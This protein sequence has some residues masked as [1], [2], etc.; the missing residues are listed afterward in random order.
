VRTSAD[1]DRDGKVTWEELTAQRQVKAGLLG[2][3][4]LNDERA[5]LEFIRQYDSNGNQVVDEQEWALVFRQQS[6]RGRFFSTDNRDDHRDWNRSH[7]AV[8][9]VLDADGDRVLSREEC[10]A[11]PAR[12]IKLDADDDERIQTY[13]VSSSQVEIP[14]MPARSQRRSSGPAL[15]W[16][17]GT[18]TDWNQFIRACQNV[19]SSGGPLATG[20]F[21]A[22]PTLFAA[23]DGDANGRLSLKE[24][25]QLAEVKPHVRLRVTWGAATTN[26]NGAACEILEWSE[27]LG[28]RKE[29][30]LETPQGIVFHDDHASYEIFPRD[31]ANESPMARAAMILAQF[32]ANKN[33]Y[34][35][36]E[37]IERASTQLGTDAKDVDADKNEQ[38]TAAEIAEYLR[39]QTSASVAQVRAV[40]SHPEDA[41]WAFL[42]EN[43]DGELDGEEIASSG[44][45]LL[46]RDRD[47]S[48]SVA[49]EELSEFAWIALVRGEAPAGLLRPTARRGPSA[50]DGPAWFR[51]MDAN[52]DGS[53]S[54]REFLGDEARFRQLD[55][56]GDGKLQVSE[57]ASQR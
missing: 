45:R 26:V 5:K 37:E 48:G 22:R 51:H 55:A 34:L 10:E 44:R 36:G 9:A 13:E 30:C 52:G 40:A 12:L 46:T 53:L 18:R 35:D 47:G 15:L 38:I 49:A 8:L 43:D 57:L 32:D 20:C 56:N 24:I 27:E 11:A 39:L 31:L 16:Q 50:T 41:F 23:L 2:N 19:Y 33:A 42:D 6:S 3:T 14:G 28:S 1:A 21:A 25:A 7:S 29:H 4:P 54:Q 17:I